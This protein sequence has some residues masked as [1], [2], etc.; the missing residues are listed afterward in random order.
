[1]YSLAEKLKINYEKSKMQHDSRTT[2]FRKV[3]S[4][5]SIH[6]WPGSGGC[7]SQD[8]TSESETRLPS[9]GPSSC[10]PKKKTGK[11]CQIPVFKFTTW[12]SLW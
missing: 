10:V 1:M 4:L 5:L 2:R 9:L 6:C 8:S 12:E 3:S 11:I 7:E